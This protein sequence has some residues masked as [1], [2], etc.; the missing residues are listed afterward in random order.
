M[1]AQTKIN[2][3]RLNIFRTQDEQINLI[4]RV[5]PWLLSSGKFILIF[6]ELI[7]IGGFMMRYLLDSQISDLDNQ[8][9]SEVNYIKARK[10]D[11]QQIRLTQFQLANIRQVKNS[12]LDF[13]T[14]LSKISQF[15]PQTASLTSIDLNK[16]ADSPFYVLTITGKATTPTEVSA[17]VA[18]LAQD[19]TFSNIDIA[20]IA[21][22]KQSIV[23]SIIGNVIP[24][25]GGKSRG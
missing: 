4:N 22:D 8:I 24:N 5:L 20:S 9:S 17:F 21:Y 2:P 1:A 23:F 12:N 7:V 19:S 10:N 16:T 18:A 11:E 14:I 6:V 15:T 25:K 13:P 3:L